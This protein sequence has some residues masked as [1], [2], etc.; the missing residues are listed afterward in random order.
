MD[1]LFGD[2]RGLKNTLLFPRHSLVVAQA[3]RRVFP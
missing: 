3:W 2:D 1:E